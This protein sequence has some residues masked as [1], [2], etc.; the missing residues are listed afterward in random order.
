M[1]E[2]SAVA[3]ALW[4]EGNQALS[5]HRVVPG[6]NPGGGTTFQYVFFYSLSSKALFYFVLEVSIRYLIVKQLSSDKALEKN[7]VEKPNEMK[8]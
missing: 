7:E 1:V 4:G 8:R 6:S 2:H 3:S 5:R